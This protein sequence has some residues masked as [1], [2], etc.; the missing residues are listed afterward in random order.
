MGGECPQILT[1]CNI[2][3]GIFLWKVWSSKTGLSEWK[4]VKE[5]RAFLLEFH[6][7]CDH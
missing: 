1:M 2:Q 3:H 7:I 4:R 6:S 5:C